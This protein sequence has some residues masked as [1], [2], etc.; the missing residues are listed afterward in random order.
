MEFN[1][2][3]CDDEKDC[4]NWVENYLDAFRRKY[5]NIKWEVFYSAEELLDYYDRHG[6]TFDILITDIE[7]NQ[8]NGVELANTIR[9][10]DKGI[11]IFFLTS[12]TEY[13]LQCFEP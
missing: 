10:R 7:M 12:Y 2:A 4:I 5:K 6:N 1:I 8:I 9:R 3:I 13:A 11:I